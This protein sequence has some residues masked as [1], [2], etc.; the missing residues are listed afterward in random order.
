MNT[1]LIIWGVCGLLTFG[2]YFAYFQN[3]YES[4]ADRDYFKDMRNGLQIGLLGPIGLLSILIRR[5]T[6]HGLKF[7]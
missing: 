1:F 5:M 6:K 3:E 7:L 2:Y 4:L